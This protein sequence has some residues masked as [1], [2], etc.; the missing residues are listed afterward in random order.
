MLALVE[1]NSLVRRPPHRELRKLVRARGLT[2][3]RAAE[4]LDV[5]RTTFFR[6]LSGASRPTTDHAI[7][8][9]ERLGFTVNHW[10]R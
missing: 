7:R 5:D 1:V 10:R 2:L 8:I 3:E 6:W 9:E 4:L